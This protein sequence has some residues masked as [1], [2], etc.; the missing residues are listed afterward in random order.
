[1]RILHDNTTRVLLQGTCQSR[2]SDNGYRG[3]D[4]LRR[5]IEHLSL[6][7]QCIGAL[8]QVVQLLAPLKDRLDRLVL[9][10]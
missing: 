4:L 1:M 5:L 6:R 3:T 9:N 8:N 10:D 2:N 7:G